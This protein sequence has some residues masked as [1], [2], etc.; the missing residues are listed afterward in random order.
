[1]TRPW[2]RRV[3]DLVSDATSSPTDVAGSSLRER[4]E[5][6]LRDDAAP[7]PES[8]EALSPEAARLLRRELRVRQVELEL[9]GEELRRVQAELG[10]ANARYF[11]LYDLAPVGYC[12]VSG[13][14]LIV[15]AN[16]T[17]ATL[18]GVTRGARRAAAVP[19]HRG[20]GGGRVGDVL[21]AIVEFG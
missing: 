3:G 15:D 6:I 12:T 7:A 18:L 16:V 8:F 14:G 20:D 19:V 11:D 21:P 10:A 4:A 13:T 2:R 17:L 5:R 1:M 9:Q